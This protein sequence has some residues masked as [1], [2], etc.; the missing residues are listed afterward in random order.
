VDGSVGTDELCW[1]KSNALVRSP[2]MARRH[3][4][5][6]GSFTPKRR[7]MNRMIEVWSNT[8]EQTQPPLLHG[9]IARNGTRGPRPYGPSTNESAL[10]AACVAV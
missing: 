4:E 2:Q 10:V 5:M 7:S 9:E 1:T 6:C 8:S 3:A